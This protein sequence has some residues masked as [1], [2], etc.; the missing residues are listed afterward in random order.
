M[1]GR[2]GV[3]VAEIVGRGL[4]AQEEDLTQALDRKD[5][6]AVAVSSAKLV[7]QGPKAGDIVY[8]ASKLAAFVEAVVKSGEKLSYQDREKLAR[9]EW[10]R[11]KKAERLPD[12]AFVTRAIVIAATKAIGKG[13]E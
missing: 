8:Y 2:R 12:D 9:R 7:A 11:I 3:S 4:D 5:P 6:N 10:S 1:G 13:R